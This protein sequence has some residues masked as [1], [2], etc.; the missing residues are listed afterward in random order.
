LLLMLLLACCL[1]P[2]RAEDADW[3]NVRLFDW[4]Y[5]GEPSYQL[6]KQAA[7]A[8]GEHGW[9][10]QRLERGQKVPQA[11]ARDLA[12]KLEDLAGLDPTVRES[13]KKQF[14]DESAQVGQLDKAGID[15][16]SA[17]LQAA[18]DRASAK[19]DLLEAS[20]ARNSYG[21]SSNPGLTMNMYSGY[22][23]DDP[24]G[25]AQGMDHGW[26]AGGVQFTLG[27]TVGKATYSLE[28]TDEYFY[29]NLNTTNFDYRTSQIGTGASISIPLND[30]GLDVVIG[31][32]SDLD[33]S[34][35]LF[36]A[37]LPLARDAF[38]ADVTTWYRAP[39]I[40]NTMQLNYPDGTYDFIGT[41]IKKE[42]AV[43]YWPFTTTEFVYTPQ[44]QTWWYS[45]DAK[46]DTT[47]FKL[48]EDI[49]P[50]GHWLDG[51]KIYGIYTSA[52][53]DADQIYGANAGQQSQN[54]TD[55]SLGLDLRFSSGT[56]F[57]LDAALSKYSSGVP[58]VVTGLSGNGLIGNFVQ[59]V[60]PLNVALEFGQASPA[61]LTLPHNAT[62][63]QA[64][65]TQ[66]T[67]QDD[68][69]T[70]YYDSGVGPGVSPAKPV[71]TTFIN[72]PTVLSN[73]SQRF[74][75]KTEW[76]GSWVSL[77]VYD[78]IMQELQP[79]DA[80]VLTTPYIEGN[81]SNGYGFFRMFFA[82]FSPPPPE[83]PVNPPTASGN[84]TG[85]WLQQEFN[86]FT[87][88]TGIAPSGS[89]YPVHWQQMSQLNNYESEFT[90]LLTQNGK[91]DPH[92]L[93]DSVKTLNYAGANLLMDFAALSNRT[94]PFALNVV[95]EVRDLAL[96]PALPTSGESSLFNQRFVVGFLNV[97]I[98]DTLT[99]LGMAGYETWESQ[100]SFYPLSMH[101]NEVGL[102]A[103]LAEDPIVTGLVFNFRATMMTLTDTNVAARELNLE[104]LSLGCTLSY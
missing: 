3:R 9:V 69:G 14:P 84:G 91:G 103:D 80:Y 95:G 65:V 93:A 86:H 54:A 33:L 77:G 26:L 99:L 79:T 98:S 23:L 102:G 2:L 49:G 62:G 85:V 21:K 50:H 48:T 37:I 100:H 32:H 20:L 55:Y 82:N 13:L 16:K 83:G 59:P 61:F 51:G 27:G 11:S 63:N 34:P 35:L 45:W 38:F 28:L 12:L 46:F 4:I 73:N 87:D 15:V 29:Q 31:G 1:A 74:T 30:G 5:S 18:L 25:L 19:L 10:A 42:G 6:L 89:S 52:G 58:I 104:S 39:K 36:S 44:D 75:L 8:V 41:Y 101:I 64:G 72:Q 92:M 57:K 90:L 60:G 24:S 56:A 40:I 94:E 22:R 66:D 78:G 53:T 88:G 71:Y 97:G 68:A 96:T 17:D 47:L 76:H 67:Y 81:Q 43:W 70:Y 7:E